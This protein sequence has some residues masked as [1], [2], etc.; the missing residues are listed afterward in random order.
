MSA[1]Q[2]TRV[3]HLVA[4]NFLGGP[5]KQILQHAL[6]LRG[7][8]YEIWVGSF[9]EN[10][11]AP[12]IIQRAS[13]LGVP[14]ILLQGGKANPAAWFNLRRRMR[15]EGIALLCTYHYKAN[16]FGWIASRYDWRVVG[17]VRGWTAENKRVRFYESLDR[18]VLNR[19]KNI[20]CVSEDLAKELTQTRSARLPR[21]YVIPN[22][23]VIPVEEAVP[24]RKLQARY[25]LGLDAETF[26]VGTVGRLSPEKGHR[27]FLHAVEQ[28]VSKIPRLEVVLL[29]DG[30]E[31]NALEK[32]AAAFGIS[33][34][35]RFLGFRED[36]HE[37]IRAF[38]VLVNPSLSEGMPNSVLESMALGT[39]V[40]ATRVGGVP[41][42]VEDGAT[43]ILVSPADPRAIEEAVFS[44]Y[45]DPQRRTV[46]S[47]A[48]RERMK[49]A[50][51]RQKLEFLSLY[52]SVLA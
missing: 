34:S 42:F 22:S 23:P 50:R 35:V 49:N 3:L 14:T 45:L 43:G 9:R 31:R 46:L 16:L 38:D 47:E 41:E 36:V 13:E 15:E 52:K 37:W 40:I 10:G 48:A 39:P 18:F 26:M 7:S 5:E 11:S 28:L 4:S 1:Q 27:Y 33:G 2:P 32:M 19:L 25:Q 6:D 21:P 24:S 20:A 12:Q 51:Q 17:S 29:G 30:Q 44:C 8:Q